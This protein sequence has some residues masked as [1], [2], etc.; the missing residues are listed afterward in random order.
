MYAEQAISRYGALKGGYLTLKR[1]IKC[2]PFHEGGYDPI[3]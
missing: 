2:N 3:P 1:I